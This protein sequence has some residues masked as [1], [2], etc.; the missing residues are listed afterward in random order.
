MAAWRFSK[1]VTFQRPPWSQTT[2]LSLRV[3]SDLIRSSSLI[4]KRH[5]DCVTVGNVPF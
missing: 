1:L 5:D 2:P 4:L 3:R